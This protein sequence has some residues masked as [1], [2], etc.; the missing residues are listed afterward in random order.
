[1]QPNITAIENRDRA[2]ANYAAA[3]HLIKAYIVR[4]ELVTYYQSIKWNMFANGDLVPLDHPFDLVNTQRDGVWLWI[5]QHET[6]LSLHKIT[7]V[8]ECLERKYGIR[9]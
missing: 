3:V 6:R 5:K 8:I 9:K 4:G 2:K 1:M 7:S